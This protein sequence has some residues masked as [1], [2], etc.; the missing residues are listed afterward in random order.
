M[1]WCQD[2]PAAKHATVVGPAGPDL[3]PPWPQVAD[4]F[5]KKYCEVLAKHPKYM[6]RF[7]HDNSQVSLR[8]V[9]SG[10]QPTALSAT[11]LEV[12]SFA[13]LAATSCQQAWAELTWGA[14]VPAGDPRALQPAPE[15]LQNPVNMLCGPVHHGGFHPAADVRLHQKQPRR[16]TGE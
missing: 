4:E 8:I 13:S 6:H 14:C 11:G 9:G 16:P 12:G 15:Q 5:R 3:L 10:P 1:A 7:Y 2:V